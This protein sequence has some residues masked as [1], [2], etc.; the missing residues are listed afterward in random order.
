MKYLIL[1]FTLITP[2]A[3][4]EKHNNISADRHAFLADPSPAARQTGYS[5]GYGF[6]KAAAYGDAVGNLPKGAISYPAK[7]FK[8][9]LNSYKCIIRWEK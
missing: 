2:V 3:S 9:G 7:F 4:P 5:V 6:N 8:I 1:L